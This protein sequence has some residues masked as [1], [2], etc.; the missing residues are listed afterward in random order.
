M[1]HE[2]VVSIKDDHPAL[3]GHF[4]NCP[5]VPGVV[6]LAEVYETL[7]LGSTAPLRIIKLPVVKFT[8]PLRP[9]EVLTVV[10][11]EHETTCAEFS[12]HVD[13]R[14]IASGSIEFSRDHI[15]RVEPT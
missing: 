7:R 6:L 8:S 5:V 3:P 4:P 2:R 11:E 9:G 14:V 13:G 15:A 1:V 10:V 12:C